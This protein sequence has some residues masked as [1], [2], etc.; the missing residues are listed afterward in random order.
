MAVATPHGREAP[1]SE[2]CWALLDRI[3]A[4]SQ[5]RRAPRLRE[6]L[7]YVSRRSLGDGRRQ[8]HEQEIGVKVFGRSDTY[9]TSVDNIVRANATELR[10]RIE[11]YFNSEGSHEQL[12][13]EI[14]RGSYIPV[15]RPRTSEP[16]TDEE[17]LSKSH[18]HVTETTAEKLP[19]RPYSAWMPATL[20][21]AGLLILL[22]SA[23][24]LNFW[25]KYHAL[26]QSLSAWEDKPTLAEFWSQLLNSNP[27][28]DMVISDTGIGLVGALRKK[29]FPLNDYLNRSYIN[30]VQYEDLSPDMH[31]AISRILAWNLA[32]PDEFALARRILAL[33]PMGHKIH[34]YYARNYT[35]DLIKQDNVILV[36]ASNSNPWDELFDSRLNFVTEFDNRVI[37]RAPAAGEQATYAPSNVDG[38][39]VLA[40]L[41]NSQNTGRVLLIEGT[42][43]EATEAAGD[44]LLS[45]DQLTAFKKMLHASTLP[46]F[47]VLLKVSSVR[48]TPLAVTVAAYRVS[49][50]APKTAG[51]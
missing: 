6:F 27:N 9:D 48:G 14:P 45:E 36:G 51:Q 47:Q 30:Q 32:S 7:L 19:A 50:A 2:E 33:D 21:G 5:L 18:A 49:T 29:T 11:A 40:Y 37:N 8:V 17:A 43:A 16:G 23:G 10:K 28:T 20:F 35:S 22:L 3:V 4:S 41:P 31:T 13:M 25:E 42:N 15:F 1:A 24:C 26:H 38:Y 12:V 34:L 44:F 39:C 46:Y